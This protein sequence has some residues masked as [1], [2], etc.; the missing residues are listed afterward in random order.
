MSGLIALL[1]FVSMAVS[2][3]FAHDPDSCE[4]PL[5]IASPVAHPDPC[6]WSELIAAIDAAMANNAF[7]HFTIGEPAAATS[8]E[9][10]PTD[11]LDG[12]AWNAHLPAGGGHH[13]MALLR[14]ES[15]DALT[16]IRSAFTAEL[17][18]AMF[19]RADVPNLE[20]ADE[21]LYLLR[22]ETA[23]ALCIFER[24]DRLIVGYSFFDLDYADV[25]LANALAL[26]RL[27]DDALATV[28]AR[29]GLR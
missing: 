4:T 21:C 19:V 18:R 1:L 24:G 6:G 28:D 7:D 11:W 3:T 26:A 29:D 17:E 8:S 25:Q 13:W 23:R 16:D 27:L 9:Y 14:Y 15:N 2:D 22:E 12:T 20:P 5:A 10:L